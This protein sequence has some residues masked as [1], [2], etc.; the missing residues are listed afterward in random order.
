LASD[1]FLDQLHDIIQACF[2][3]TD[4][5]L[6]RF[7]SG[8]SY[9]STETEY[10]LCPFEVEE[11]E[12]GVPEEQVRLDEVLVDV[13]DKLFYTYDFGDDWEH[14]VKLEAV[15]PRTDAAPRAV[16]TAGRRPGPPEDCGGVYAYEIIA[17]SIDVS[18]SD[19]AERATEFTELFGTDVDPERFEFTPFDRDEINTWLS[20]LDL[21][22][23]R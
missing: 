3:W 14:V 19:H 18:S 7:A 17:A 9:Y 5:H 15:L 20:D 8:P 16:C 11:E 21:D 10:Y 12:A 4:S 22:S 2:G 23:P 6:H 1:L 13:G